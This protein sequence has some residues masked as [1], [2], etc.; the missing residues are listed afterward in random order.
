MRFHGKSLLSLLTAVALVISSSLA[1]SPAVAQETATDKYLETIKQAVKEFDLGNWQEARALFKQAH[2]MNPNARTLRG[3]GMAAYEM[4]NYLPALRDLQAA[5][6]ETRKP[7]TGEQR[8][9]VNQLIERIHAFLGRFQVV[10]EPPN[11]TLQVDGQVVELDDDRELVL[12][13]GEHEVTAMASDYIEQTQKI[14]VEGGENR[15]LS[16]ML[17]PVP[18]EPVAAPVPVVPPAAEPT[19]KEPEKK[20]EEPAREKPKQQ[21]KW[22]WP[23]EEDSGPTWAWVAFGAGALSGGVA[24]LFWVMGEQKYN[25]LKDD[26]ENWCSQEDRDKGEE[27]VKD[28]DKLATIF[29]GTA[30]GLGGLSIILFIVESVLATESGEEQEASLDIGPGSIRLRGSF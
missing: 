15:E 30:I 14:T 9:Q 19:A 3:M 26:C 13:L 6:K 24:G 17:E 21:Q 23:E 22:E 27:E 12:E 25:D 5:L 28:A 8:Q 18:E 16:F 2:R 11:A 7:L 29:L 10:M 20:P 4:R 1:V